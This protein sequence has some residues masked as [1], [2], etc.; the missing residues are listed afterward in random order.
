MLERHAITTFQPMLT[1]VLFAVNFNLRHFM[2]FYWKKEE[3]IPGT[4]VPTMI[5]K[6]MTPVI[7]AKGNLS[8]E[9]HASNIEQVQYV[10]SEETI[11]G[12]AKHPNVTFAIQITRKSCKAYLSYIAHITFIKAQ[13]FSSLDNSSKKENESLGGVPNSYRTKMSG[14][15]N[16][17]TIIMHNDLHSKPQKLGLEIRHGPT[18]FNKPV[19]ETTPAFTTFY[20][21]FDLWSKSKELYFVLAQDANLCGARISVSLNS[22]F[23]INRNE[24]ILSKFRFYLY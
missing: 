20:E 18:L 1:S 19:D 23:L 4:R 21:T 8:Y 13:K 14:M 5:T 7:T 9:S 10:I 3:T 6:Y 24:F 15:S 17:E 16:V 12:Y 11:K 2:I 22:E